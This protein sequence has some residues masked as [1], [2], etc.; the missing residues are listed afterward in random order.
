M[1]SH[2]VL[3]HQTILVLDLVSQVAHDD[4]HLDVMEQEHLEL[5]E[6]LDILKVSDAMAVLSS[7]LVLVSQVA[8]VDVHSD[9]LEQQHSKSREM[10]EIPKVSDVTATLSSPV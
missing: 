4:V 8:H 6:M 10:E 9:V 3:P 1:H 2:Q 7:Q 5:W